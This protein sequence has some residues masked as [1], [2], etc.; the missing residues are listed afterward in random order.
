M[1]R[2]CGGTVLAQDPG[3]CA[4]P[5]M[6][7]AAIHEGLTDLVLT[8]EQIAEEIVDRARSKPGGKP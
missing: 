4:V 6:P 7:S 2:A 1:V 5:G 8:P 3:T